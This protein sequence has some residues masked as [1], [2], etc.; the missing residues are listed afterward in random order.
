MAELI[1]EPQA[2]PQSVRRE[3]YETYSTQLKPRHIKKLIENLDEI[4]GYD[5]AFIVGLIMRSQ[6]SGN[7]NIVSIQHE[8]S[9]ISFSQGKITKIDLND[10]ETF[11]GELLIKE[12]Y[13]DR[14]KLLSILT[15]KSKPL[16][17]LLIQSK[18]ANKEQIIGIL[19]KQMR[20]R[21][22]KYI[23][24][25]KFRINFSE[26]EVPDQGLSISYLDFLK[27]AHD[28]V[29]G[30]FDGEWLKLHYMELS[31]GIV[32]IIPDTPNTVQIKNLPLSQDLQIALNKIPTDKIL[33][34][35]LQSFK[36]EKDREY[37][38]KSFHYGIMTGQI[39]LKENPDASVNNETILKNIYQACN[40]KT[41]IELLETLAHILKHKPTEIEQIFQSITDY[42]EA[43]NGDDMDMKNNMFR[44][45][46][47]MLSKKQY[48]YEEIHKKYSAENNSDISSDIQSKIQEVYRDLLNRNVDNSIIKLKKISS[49]SNHLPKIKL[50]MVW[51]KLLI[52]TQKKIK[53][54]IAEIE[55]EF[56][57]ILPEDKDTAEYFYVKALISQQKKEN[58]M[59][60]AYY[61]QAVQMNNEFKA[62]PLQTN[63]SFFKRLF[64]LSCFAFFVLLFN[65]KS[66]AQKAIPPFNFLNQYFNYST[67]EIGTLDINDKKYDL[68]DL[69][70]NQIENGSYTLT[71]DGSLQ[72]FIQGA[73]AQFF[74]TQTNTFVDLKTKTNGENS[75]VIL[76]NQ[77]VTNDGL[78]CLKRTSAYTQIKICKA[79]ANNTEGLG[80]KSVMAN[81]LALEQ[82]GSVV[83]NDQNQK[84][85]F[86]VSLN[87]QSFF[88]LETMKRNVLPV[89]LNKPNN[90]DNII[91]QFVDAGNPRYAWEDT[92]NVS[93]D[94]FP[95]KFDPLISLRQGIYFSDRANAPKGI[96]Q[97]YIN[98]S[99][100]QQKFYNKLSVEP[101][102]IFNE[103]TG[104]SSTVNALLRSKIGLGLQ[105]SGDH[106]LENGNNIF[107]Y[108]SIFK[109]EVNPTNNNTTIEDAVANY[110]A[111]LGGYKYNINNKW[112]L[113]GVV[114]LQQDMFFY[115][116]GASSVKLTKSL[117]KMIGL[118][119]EYSI[120]NKNKWDIYGGIYGYLILPT[121]IEGTSSAQTGT[122]FEASLRASYKV[123]W[124]RLQGSLGMGNR[125]QKNSTM[126]YSD[127]FVIYRLGATYL[128]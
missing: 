108:I 105:F 11:M 33:S 87:N 100:I 19:I 89:K 93:S 112:S 128:F 34:K 14:E 102:T 85:V 20:L 63:I 103:F 115:Q 127:T 1:D 114:K 107:G 24:N 71:A 53:I 4:Y 118:Y 126:S 84:I 99:Q 8:I 75:I 6:L 28:W 27:L 73:N 76:D 121:D 46:L 3:L 22:S 36:I 90:S 56:L 58:K 40:K 25:S 66:Y 106:Y 113:S 50:F 67:N 104:Q 10:K 65:T 98:K 55:R 49:Y 47:E 7:L 54:N 125:S 17:E 5:L 13:L 12:G 92:V 21:L 123:N 18:V 95:I 81:G 124:G 60:E 120:Y 96:A 97:I 82:T 44:I 31:E 35:F 37:F 48:Y 32:E 94:Y 88:E 26:A 109:T 38:L 70:V 52:I 111:V 59:A 51:S 43:Y 122:A 57:Q 119:P 61:K 68:S 41:G 117:N 9:G 74:N 79:I 110:I 83:L 101:L 23:T 77:L 15:D 2:T 86:N 64:K 78:L 45:V 80:L 39:A 69:Q 16:G 29:A 30:R 62:H 72:D 116:T 91:M 42:V